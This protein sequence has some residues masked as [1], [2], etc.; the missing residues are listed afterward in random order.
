M[1]KCWILK[2]YLTNPNTEPSTF[3]HPMLAMD[4]GL[5]NTWLID[6]GCSRHMTGVTKWF[7]NLTHML[8]HVFD[9]CGNLVCDFSQWLTHLM[10]IDFL[11][12]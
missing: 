6:S 4:G 3:S 1:V 10:V 2:I 9:S 5:E 8:F 7:F 11:K 12:A